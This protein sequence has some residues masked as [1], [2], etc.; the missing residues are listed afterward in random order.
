MLATEDDL[1]PGL[2]AVDFISV[3]TGCKG[4][5]RFFLLAQQGFSLESVSVSEL[6]SDP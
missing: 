6:E 4:A 2:G 1:G 5:P 3:L